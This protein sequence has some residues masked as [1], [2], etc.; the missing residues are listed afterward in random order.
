[1][2][3]RLDGP[4]AELVAAERDQVDTIS[5]SPDAAW[6]G[7]AAAWQ[8]P[9]PIP[10]GG[11][12]EAATTTA[13]KAGLL[14]AAAAVVVGISVVAGGWALQGAPKDVPLARVEAPR[15]D[16]A[17]VVEVPPPPNTDVAPVSATPP[18]RAPEIEAHLEPIVRAS[19]RPK[20]QP[21]LAEE[22]ALVDSMRRDVAAGRFPQALTRAKKHRDTFAK[23]ALTAD[24]MDL[25]AAARCGH[26]DLKAGQK[27]AER[28]ADRW[29]RAPMS[30]RLRTLCKLEQP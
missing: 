1:M 7:I 6:A 16:V 4:L 2:M 26:G 22:L 8:A 18:P 27:L 25:E 15:V 24:R 5:K 11:A 12:A 23:G 14:K 29:P 17:G 9:P 30:D 10:P 20:P 13:G 19:S 3:E 28:K 21:G